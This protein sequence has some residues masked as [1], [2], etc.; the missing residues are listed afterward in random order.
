VSSIEVRPFESRSDYLSMIEYFTSGSPEFL[1]GMGVD[2]AKMPDRD[3]WLERAWRDHQLPEDDAGRERFY[4]GWYLDGELIGHSSISQIRWGEEAYI[5]LHM[6]K[7]DRRRSGIGSE[8][9]RKSIDFFYDRFQLKRLYCEPYA[10][11]PAP[12]RVLE[13]LGYKP[14]KRYRTTPGPINFEQ[15]VNRYEITK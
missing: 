1:R 4:V 11:N 3:A 2:P 13:K 15:D 14:V 5:H 8:F 12:N 10:E 7:A 6:W 9:F